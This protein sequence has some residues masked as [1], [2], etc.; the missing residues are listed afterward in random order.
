MGCHRAGWTWSWDRRRWKPEE[1]SVGE[2]KEA[3]TEQRYRQDGSRTGTPVGQ[4]HTGE[5]HEQEL[6]V[7]AGTFL[8]TQGKHKRQPGKELRQTNSL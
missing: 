6:D 3:G 2:G 1:H 8:R 5:V 7:K 4:E